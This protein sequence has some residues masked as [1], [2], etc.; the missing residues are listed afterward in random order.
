[1]GS[2]TISDAEHAVSSMKAL[3]SALAE[4]LEDV[5]SRIQELGKNSPP[6]SQEDG[7]EEAKLHY[8]ARA[9]LYGAFAS[10]NEVLGWVNLMVERDSNGN[11]AEAVKSLPTIPMFSIH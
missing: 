11:V 7:D 10:I 8:V 6:H 9:A 5:E 2:I 3:Q 4:E 1:M